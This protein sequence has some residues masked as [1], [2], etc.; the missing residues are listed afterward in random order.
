MSAQQTF[1][2]CH[3]CRAID[4]GVPDKNGVFQRDSAATTTRRTGK[5]RMTTRDE[6]SPRLGQ[7]GGGRKESTMRQAHPFTDQ[8]SEPPFLPPSGAGYEIRGVT[9]ELAAVW[10]TYLHAGAWL[11]DSEINAA[12]HRIDDGSA[13]EFVIFNHDGDLISGQNTLAAL[14][15]DGVTLDVIVIR[16][17]AESDGAADEVQAD[18]DDARHINRVAYHLAK[19]VLLGCLGRVPGDD[20]ICAYV[21]E[22]EGALV[23]AR[24]RAGRLYTAIGGS[25]TGYARA[26]YLMAQIDEPLTDK[27]ADGLR[28]YFSPQVTPPIREAGVALLRERKRLNADETMWFLSAA[29]N[30]LRGGCGITA[31]TLTVPRSEVL[32]R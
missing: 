13:T 20:A 11:D 17:T 10:L 28:H 6:K 29:W 1:I 2:Y 21:R 32:P 7:V 24:R 26:F 16:L 12:A 31:D 3:D 27:F 30:R 18:T 19:W 4:Y 9:P 23:E 5:D 22:H 15:R 8:Y 25:L 14:I